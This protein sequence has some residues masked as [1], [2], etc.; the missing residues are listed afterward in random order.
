MAYR[1]I[2]LIQTQKAFQL[3]HLV[4]W[5]LA[6]LTVR[7]LTW[8]SPRCPLRSHSL[9]CA[10]NNL[11]IIGKGLIL[12]KEFGFIFRSDRSDRTCVYTYVSVLCDTF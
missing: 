9:L 12:N 6:Y 1:K 4:V 11:F 2:T 10:E 3:E 8:S 5:Y 7:L